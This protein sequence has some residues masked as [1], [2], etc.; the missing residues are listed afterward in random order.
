[1]GMI[2]G[3]IAVMAL[4]GFLPDEL[5]WVFAIACAIYLVSVVRDEQ[6]KHKAH[7]EAKRQA[8]WDANPDR[9]AWWDSKVK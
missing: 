2:L 7:L 5:K 8:Y 1:M 3:F 4:G 6:A 9:K